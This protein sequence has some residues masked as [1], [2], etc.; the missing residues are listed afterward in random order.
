MIQKDGTV[1]RY[2][3]VP[4]TLSDI[5]KRLPPRRRNAPD[6]MS[7]EELKQSKAPL[8]EPAA[9]FKSVTARPSNNDQ[10][11]QE[12]SQQGMRQPGQLFGPLQMAAPGLSL[13]S[14]QELDLLPG[15]PLSN[16]VFEP[17]PAPEAIFKD[18]PESEQSE[19]SQP[20]QDQAKQETQ[21]NPIKPTSRGLTSPLPTSDSSLR[22]K[23]RPTPPPDS[24]RPSP[25]SNQSS[26]R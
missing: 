24:D 26:T 9:L 7:P 23:R 11:R 18:L 8:V 20:I 21:A 10:T 15:L 6:L 22:Y 13:S 3:P 25:P 5:M 14:P 1:T 17:L 2:R 12:V 4:R 19:Q 16:L